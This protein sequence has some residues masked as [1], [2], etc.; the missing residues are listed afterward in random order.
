MS[1]R[2]ILGVVHAERFLGSAYQLWL[3][4]RRVAALLDLVPVKARKVVVTHNLLAVLRAA[5][6]PLRRVADQELL[7]Q[8]GRRGRERVRE[9]DLLVQNVV[10]ELVNVAR[11]PK[12]R[13]RGGQRW[14]IIV[15][16][17]FR[18]EEDTKHEPFRRASRT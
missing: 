12:R 16:H 13:L 18:P 7:Q 5:A 2:V 10:E 14:V 3:E 8:R 15:K 11:R 17:V 9:V 4:L 1:S 6:E